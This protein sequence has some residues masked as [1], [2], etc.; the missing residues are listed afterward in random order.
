MSSVLGHRKNLFEPFKIER[1]WY[2]PRS[3][4]SYPGVLSFTPNYGAE[5]E[6]EDDAKLS[7]L[8]KPHRILWGTSRE[9]RKSLS[10]VYEFVS[11]FQSCGV[12]F[13]L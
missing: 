13:Y 7:D 1:N 3:D 11:D 5:L 4:V 2:Q 9:R 10:K 6:V 12:K 8:V